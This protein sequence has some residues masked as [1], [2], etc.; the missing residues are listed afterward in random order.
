MRKTEGGSEPCGAR[1]SEHGSGAAF[2]RCT[3]RLQVNTE[4]RQGARMLKSPYFSGKLLNF[5][6]QHFP[7]PIPK[8]SDYGLSEWRESRT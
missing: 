3:R 5:V 8:Y 1:A 7:T 6:V 4:R 2:G